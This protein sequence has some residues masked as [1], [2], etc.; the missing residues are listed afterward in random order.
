MAGPNRAGGRTAVSACRLQRGAL[1]TT[2]VAPSMSSAPGP[3]CTVTAGSWRRDGAAMLVA[4]RLLVA[5][6]QAG[7]LGVAIHRAC[8][9][10]WGVDSLPARSSAV[11]KTA[12]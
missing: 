4:C 3:A 10:L 11:T 12:G 6:P 1:L 5:A 9:T 8:R 7:A 2:R